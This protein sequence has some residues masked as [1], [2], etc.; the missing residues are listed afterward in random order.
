MVHFLFLMIWKDYKRKRSPSHND[1]LKGKLFPLAFYKK[2]VFNGS[3]GKMNYRIEKK[4]N[5]EN[6]K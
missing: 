6:K 3:K 1:D 5:E 2:S 4:E